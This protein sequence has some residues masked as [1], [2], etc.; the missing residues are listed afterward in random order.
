MSLATRYNLGMSLD[1][2]CD[3][4]TMYYEAAARTTVGFVER[5]FGMVSGDSK[6]L[7]L[8]GPFAI[9][10]GFSLDT[11]LDRQ[12]Q[13]TSQDFVELFDMQGAYGSTDSLNFLG[14]SQLKGTGKLERDFGKAFE[15]FQKALD[16]DENDATANYVLG[17]M[18]MIGITPSR[19]VDFE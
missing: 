3:A 2:D 14:F 12:N 13:Y 15:L 5:T 11:L 6:Q 19:E 10:E 18:N 1:E 7:A 4:S 9:Q 17:L 16:I 8:M